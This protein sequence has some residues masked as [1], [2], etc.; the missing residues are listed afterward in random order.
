MVRRRAAQSGLVTLEVT[1]TDA[2]LPGD[3]LIVRLLRNTSSADILAEG[4]L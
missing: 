3:V 4:T 2:I 1:E